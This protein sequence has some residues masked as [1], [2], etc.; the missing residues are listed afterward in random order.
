MRAAIS[1]IG[2]SV[3][4]NRRQTSSSFL[5]RMAVATPSS[6]TVSGAATAEVLYENRACDVEDGR[7]TDD[8]AP[9]AVH[10]YR[11]SSPQ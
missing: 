10:I 4:I 8:F 3:S 2:R 6:L 7:I 5:F 11:L 9:F 1:S